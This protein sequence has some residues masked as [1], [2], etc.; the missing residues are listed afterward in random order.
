MEILWDSMHYM[1]LEQGMKLAVWDTKELKQS[2]L[3][4]I[5]SEVRNTPHRTVVI[6]S[7]NTQ[8]MQHLYHLPEFQIRHSILSGQ[9]M[10]LVNFHAD[11][12]RKLLKE[13]GEASVTI[14][15]KPFLEGVTGLDEMKCI[16]SE[17]DELPEV[18]YL[19]ITCQK[20]EITLLCT[21]LA[22]VQN[23]ENKYE[24]HYM[25]LMK[26]IVQLLEKSSAF[27]NEFIEMLYVGADNFQTALMLD[28]MNRTNSWIAKCEYKYKQEQ[29]KSEKIGS[30]DAVDVMQFQKI[31]AFIRERNSIDEYDIHTFAELGQHG[32]EMLGRCIHADQQMHLLDKD[33]LNKMQQLNTKLEEKNE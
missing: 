2:L 20:M 25:E 14:P 30:V 19:T 7:S 4:L 17:E 15:L 10:L 11:S 21:V 8:L 22:N 12:S 28:Y 33:T 26:E 31:L 32:K 3:N 1:E 16:W 5:R 9:D 23:E 13:D 6:L 29:K 24:I 18:P 27:K